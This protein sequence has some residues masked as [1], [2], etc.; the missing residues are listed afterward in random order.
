MSPPRIVILGAGPAGLGAAF[1]LARREVASVVVLEQQERVGGSAGSLELAG[2]RVDYGSHRLHPACDPA[3]LAD[4]R[5]LLGK[6][7]LDRPRH[8]RIRLQE[9]WVHFPLKPLDLATHLPPG[10]ALGTAA[11]MAKRVLRRRAAMGEETFA[12][13]LEAGLGRTICR[14]FYFP[15]AA[16]L[17]GVAPEQL[18]AIQATRRVS[19]DSLA[20]VLRKTLSAVPGLKPA[21]AGRFYYP[22]HGF[23]Q[24]SEAYHDAASA[25]G[26]EFHLGATV[27]GLALRDDG[28]GRVSF[29]VHGAHFSLEADHIW[30]TIPVTD[31]ARLLT[32]APPT[33]VLQAA[34]V[35]DSRAMLLIY[36]VL[37]QGRFTE[38]DAHYFPGPRI[39]IS[40][41]SEPKNYS[42]AELP[43][44]TT[45]LCAEL[46]CSPTDPVWQMTDDQLGRLVCDGLAAAGIPIRVPVRQVTAWRLRQA[47]PIYRRGYEAAFA[48]LDA[49]L[50]AVRGLLTFGRQGL[51]AHDNTHHALYMGY[52]AADC[53]GEDGRFD[54]ERWQAFRQEFKGHVVED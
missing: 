9:R 44:D 6:D 5:G 10:F 49:W 46:P 37:E 18:S 40:R 3:I 35:L 26:V 24:I 14:E 51:F 42:D 36:L 30:C 21:G 39:A 17:W 22:R 16:K 41:L 13:V 19:A 4:I 52:C 53:V 33:E 15:Y 7:L 8:G 27:Q 25:A 28:G 47:Y 31:M 11:D 2:Q 45:V 50:G 12:S 34:S 48:E 38:Y 43:R 29:A 1:Q 20:K 23:G 32:P 54:R